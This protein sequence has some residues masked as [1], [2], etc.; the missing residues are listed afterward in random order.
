[1]SPQSGLIIVKVFEAELKEAKEGR[2]LVMDTEVV[3]GVV[4]GSV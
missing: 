2:V 3:D 4:E 1:M